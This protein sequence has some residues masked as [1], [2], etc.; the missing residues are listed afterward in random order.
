VA[1]LEQKLKYSTSFAQI[2]EPHAGGSTSGSD[3]YMFGVSGAVVAAA[4]TR[5]QTLADAVASIS[6]GSNEVS[7]P[8]HAGLADQVGQ[9]R[10]SL[11]FG[12]VDTT[13]VGAKNPVALRD[14]DSISQDVT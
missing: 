7:Q 11:S 9:T 10:L 5:S 3:M 4:S 2:S 8:R 13:V 12:L 14:G 1:E 6:G